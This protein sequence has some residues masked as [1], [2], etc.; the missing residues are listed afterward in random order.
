MVKAGRFAEI[1]GML[2]PLLVHPRR[3][4]DASLRAIVDEMFFAIGPE[5]HIR[6]Q[7]AIMGRADM[8]GAL[9]SIGCP[10]LIVV[11]DGDQLTPP[12]LAKEISDGIGGSR[13]AVVPEC[14]HLST[15]EQPD[16]VTRTLA[17]W[18]QTD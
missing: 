14:G 1:P 5:A 2:F 8:R 9:S 7:T 4:D 18:L 3:R 12:A 16:F 11:G 15:L 13:L 10:T 6:Q 17:E